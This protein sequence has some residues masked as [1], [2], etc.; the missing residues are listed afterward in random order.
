MYLPPKTQDAARICGKMP[1]LEFIGVNLIASF[2]NSVYKTMRY[3]RTSV[4]Y[5]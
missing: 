2:L 1:Q 4:G 5:Y 3:S